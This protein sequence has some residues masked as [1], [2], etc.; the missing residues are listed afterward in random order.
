MK[1]TQKFTISL[2]LFGFIPSA[3][4]AGPIAVCC[5]HNAYYE[6]C[7]DYVCQRDPILGVKSCV[8]K[9]SCVSRD[10]GAQVDGVC[11]GFEEDFVNGNCP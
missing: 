6:T 10:T 8:W 5:Q 2:L 4:I 7:W 1:T 9:T 11:S 3:C